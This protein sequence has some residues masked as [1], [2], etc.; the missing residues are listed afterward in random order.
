MICIGRESDENHVVRSLLDAVSQQKIF[1]LLSSRPSGRSVLDALAPAAELAMRPLPTPAATELAR[2]IIGTE[3]VAAIAAERSKG[4]P[5]FVEQFAA[6]AA[7]TDYQGGTGGPHSL[8][9]VIA[10]RIAHL[11]DV[12]LSNIRQTLRWRRGWEREAVE[13]ELDRL[14][15]EIGLWLDRLE[16]GDYA[17]RVEAAGYLI[18]LERVDFE[19]FLASALAG[20]ARPRSSRLR[21]EIERLLIGSA[22]HLARRSRKASVGCQR[23]RRENIA[24]DAERGGDYAYAAF[25][26]PLATSFYKLALE[27]SP[28]RR[29]DELGSRLAECVR[30]SR[31]VLDDAAKMVEVEAAKNEDIETRPMVDMR[32]L[33]AVWLHLAYRHASREYFL[34]AA[35]A[36]EAIND[37]ALAKWARRE[38]GQA[39]PGS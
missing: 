29:T 16:T 21:E 20:K 32:R 8:H 7:K 14:E 30:R 18:D 2:Q 15:A 37:R 9:Q 19:I 36:A 4:N 6:W 13:G 22:H 10:A 38:A 33:P 28:S 3:A 25:N 35:E 1:V 17:D 26:W 27:L 11:S 34:R 39:A 12:R 31:P 5:L 23:R 24:R